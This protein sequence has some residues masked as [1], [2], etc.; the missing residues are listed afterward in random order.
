[1]QNPIPHSTL[2]KTPASLEELQEIANT[3]S[4]ASEAWRMMVFT[5]NFCHDI[6]KQEPRIRVV[7]KGHNGVHDPEANAEEQ[8]GRAGL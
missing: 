3:M 1:M 4:N 5:L 2:F 6:V 7:N 8:F